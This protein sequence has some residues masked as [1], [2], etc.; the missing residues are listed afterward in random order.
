MKNNEKIKY[1]VVVIDSRRYLVFNQT[2]ILIEDNNSLAKFLADNKE[3]IK[4]FDVGLDSLLYSINDQSGSISIKLI[5]GS[6]IKYVNG[7]PVSFVSEDLPTLEYI[8]SDK[9]QID[10]NKKIQLG[11]DKESGIEFLK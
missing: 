10:Y 7:V 3:I 8:N 9:S 4:S 5:S 1:L 6:I 2:A 11:Y